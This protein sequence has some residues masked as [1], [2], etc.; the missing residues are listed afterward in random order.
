MASSL[1]LAAGVLLLSSSASTVALAQESHDAVVLLFD[2]SGSM[3][4]TDPACVR[5]EAASL[6]VSLLDDGDRLAV[7]EFGDG[8]QQATKDWVRVGEGRAELSKVASR[9]R[10]DAKFTNIVEALEESLT[11]V[12]SLGVEGRQ[13]TPPSIVVLTDGRDTSRETDRAA[14]D[15][16]LEEVLAAL[17]R[18]G[19]PVHSVGLSAEADRDLLGRLQIATGGDISI[20][21]EPRDLLGSFFDLSRGLSGRWLIGD[22]AVAD[23]PVSWTVPQWARGGVV[24]FVP[25]GQSAPPIEIAGARATTRRGYQ[26]ALLEELPEGQLTID[27]PPGTSGRAVFD[28]RGDLRLRL[29]VGERIPQDIPFTCRATLVAPDGVPLGDGAFLEAFEVAV[30]PGWGAASN[31]QPL[32]DNGR[33]D[34]GG[35]KDGGFGGTCF[36][37]RSPTEGATLLHATGRGR[38]TRT[39]HVTQAVTVVEKPVLLSTKQ[40]SL[41]RLGWGD[42]RLDLELTNDTDVQIPVSA[43]VEADG[44]SVASEKLALLPGSAQTVPVDVP[45]KPFTSTDVAVR[46][47]AE[48]REAPLLD[49]RIGI[50]PAATI[51]LS[52]AA[53]VLLL[54]G[55]FLFPK[56]TATGIDVSVDLDKGGP[57][58]PHSS[59]K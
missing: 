44:T 20:A 59:A 7:L 3:K 55:S 31:P 56:R 48:G 38:H 33:H 18:Y 1:A 42:A 17:G 15:R 34:D 22:V 37:T 30:Q 8:V 2:V 41:S 24:F 26:I 13:A 10:S 51:P 53:V 52:A 49:Q 11:L 43:N 21:K 29:D 25:D 57:V 27:L 6:L 40:T 28:A 9:C 23:Q 12:E 58:P 54:L 5:G 46:V 32:Y 16:R 45:R 4:A 47:T 19:V 36:A 14:R 50:S 39:L 35:A